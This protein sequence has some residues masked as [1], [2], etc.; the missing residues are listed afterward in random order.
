MSEITVALR[1]R[2][3]KLSAL[4]D[5]LAYSMPASFYTDADWLTGEEDMLR[6]Q[7]MCIGHVG[8]VKGAR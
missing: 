4:P 7:W 2:L 8:E 6:R 1:A 5:D 3:Y